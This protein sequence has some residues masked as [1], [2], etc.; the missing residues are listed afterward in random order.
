MA[1]SLS[2]TRLAN[3]SDRKLKSLGIAPR[4]SN[5]RELPDEITRTLEIMEELNWEHPHALA[6]K[7]RAEQLEQA[8]KDKNYRKFVLEKIKSDPVYFINNWV[9]T[10][11]PREYPSNI[12]FVLFPKQEEYIR[13]RYDHIQRKRGGLIEKSRDAGLTWLNC[14]SHVQLWLT[15]A[16]YKGAIGSRKELLVDRIGDLDSIFEK[17]RFILKCLPWWMLKQSSY[18]AGYLKIINKS[19]GATITG[20]AGDEQGRGGRSTVRDADEAAFFERPKRI[21]AAISQNSNVIFYTSTPNGNGNPFATKRRSG[22]WDVFTI[23][24]KDDPRKSQAWYDEQKRI[25]D[26]IILASEVDIDYDSS[27]PNICIPAKYV[28][29]AINA[30]LGDPQ[31][32][33]VGGLD[34]SDEGSDETVLTIWQ[35]PYLMAIHARTEGNA[36]QKTYW[37]KL[38]CEQNEVEHLNY[39]SIGVGATVGGNLK[40]VEDLAFTIKAIVGGDSPSDRFYPEL[41]RKGNK[42][43]KNLRAELWW[44]LRRRFE[45]TY[46]HMNGIKQYPEEELISI[47]DDP[48]LIQQLSLPTYFFNDSGKLCIEDKESMAKRE[49]GS[50]DRADSLVY[51]TAPFANLSWLFK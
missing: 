8:A 15:R 47:P 32:R 35:S 10:S 38:L 1:S 29:A 26:P 19:N 13:W 9:W 42:F 3:S 5:E 40:A 6:I 51:A 21:D 4:S 18:S 41:N 24:W 37:A 43:F 34:I 25:L 11:D 20:E 48:T 2:L 36:T 39:D 50:P 14:S 45:K 44:S 12:P 27:R 28:R 33:K 22:K 7:R 49:L 23:H 31:G 17:I 46:E 30:V 16:D